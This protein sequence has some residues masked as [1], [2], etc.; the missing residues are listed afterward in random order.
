MFFSLTIKT[1][2][3]PRMK[4]PWQFAGLKK[5]VQLESCELSFIWGQ[6]EDCSPGVSIS[7]RSERLLPS[8]SG[9]RS[10]YKV[11]VNGEFNIMKH[12]FYK[13]LFVSHKDLISTMKGFSASLGMRRCKD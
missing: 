13:K 4:I 7:E 6:N 2:T 12:S 9:R 11:L 3:I 8:G 1:N 10:I 5:D